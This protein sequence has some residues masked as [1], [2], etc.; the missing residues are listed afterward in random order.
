[1]IT[2]DL[3]PGYLPDFI[4]DLLANPPRAGEGVHAYLY[5]VALKLHPYRTDEEIYSVAEGIRQRLRALCP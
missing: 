4:R 1:M 3:G 2:L 5:K